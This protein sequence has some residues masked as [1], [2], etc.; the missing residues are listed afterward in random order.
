MEKLL[1]GMCQNLE[2]QD[3]DYMLSGSLAMGF[4]TIPRLT[5]D[6]DIVIQLQQKDVEKFI[7]FFSIIIITGKASRKRAGAK[8]CSTLLTTKP[9]LR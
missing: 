1:I 6:I 9:A 2:S 7:P 5:R 8:E 4:Y 3:I